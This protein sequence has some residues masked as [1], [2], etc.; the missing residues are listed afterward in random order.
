MTTGISYYSHL[1]AKTLINGTPVQAIE[2]DIDINTTAVTIS[3]AVL[4]WQQLPP[5]YEEPKAQESN[6]Q[7][8]Y[9][10]T[11]QSL[12]QPTAITLP[13]PT[14]E[15]P[16]TQHTL[17]YEVLTSHTPPN[18]CM[19]EYD[20]AAQY[21]LQTVLQGTIKRYMIIMERN[22][23]RDIQAAIAPIITQTCI[24]DPEDDP[25]S[26]YLPHEP[27]TSAI[28][29]YVRDICRPLQAQH[30]LDCAPFLR[31]II[32]LTHDLLNPL[33][34]HAA[35]IND[36]DMNSFHPTAREYN[37]AFQQILNNHHQQMTTVFTTFIT[38]HITSQQTYYHTDSFHTSPMGHVRYQPDASKD[39]FLR[40]RTMAEIQDISPNF[41]TLRQ[42]TAN[43]ITHQC[44][45]LT[46]EVTAVIDR[47]LSRWL[48]DLTHLSEL[49][50]IPIP[51]PTTP[52]PPSPDPQSSP[53]HSNHMHTCVT[54]P[55]A[56]H[57]VS[58]LCHSLYHKT[59]LLPPLLPNYCPNTP[60]MLPNLRHLA[61]NHHNPDS[62]SQ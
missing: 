56:P 7:R 55:S 11:T 15:T 50:G 5:G 45:L 28:Y 22:I 51:A 18:A 16:D 37:Q 31:S 36:P 3:P 21:H 43:I 17:L 46:T 39:H 23:I 40:P 25:E 33:Q 12:H 30:D 60:K 32:Q 26:A 44:H 47:H 29:T 2:R 41:F 34:L 57:S 48:A 52:H 13:L 62:W 6:T 4:I 59:H 38:T 53:T 49:H 42:A 14:L 54:P 8:K 61:K 1:H 19:R 24:G 35:I 9:Q 20:R 58:Q 10:D 27:H